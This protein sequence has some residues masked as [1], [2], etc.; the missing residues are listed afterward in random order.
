MTDEVTAAVTGHIVILVCGYSVADVERARIQASIL[1]A[2]GHRVTLVAPR[3]LQGPPIATAGGK[4]TMRNFDGELFQSPD[5]PMMQ[6]A[7]SHVQLMGA[8][9][10]ACFGTDAADVIQLSGPASRLLPAA[11]FVRLAGRPVVKDIRGRMADIYAA[12]SMTPRPRRARGLALFD[13]LALAG[14]DLIVTSEPRLAPKGGAAR[15]VLMRERAFDGLT[16]RDGDRTPFANNRAHLVTGFS[17]FD[18]GDRVDVLLRTMR[19]IVFGLERTDIQFAIV[20]PRAKHSALAQMAQ[21]DDVTAFVTLVD[22]QDHDTLSELLSVSDAVV[23]PTMPGAQ[24]AGPVSAFTLSAAKF[25]LPLVAFDR[26]SVRERFGAGATIV[27]EA[28]VP[29]LADSLLD[30]LDFPEEMAAKKQAARE[31]FASDLSFES[32]A[33]AYGDAVMQLIERRARTDRDIVSHHTEAAAKQ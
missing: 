20:A 33:Q 24:N 18:A 26:P 30:L 4:I 1:S 27:R 11:L 32:E 12:T 17:D 15:S 29:A 2:R 31:A 8:V 3:A 28:Q 19:R 21:A 6:V 13:R 22:T 10:R 5:Q 7:K 9:L 23:D 25:G 16:P 14:R